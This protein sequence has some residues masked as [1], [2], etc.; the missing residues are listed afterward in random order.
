VR[1]PLPADI[2][3]LAAAQADLMSDLVAGM[4]D[5]DL[6]APTRCAGWLA[7]HLLVHVRLG[8]AETTG[9]F[10]QPAGAAEVT[11]RD[12]ISYWRD[13]PA[14]IEPVT[15][16]TVRWHWA[17]ASAYSV[18]AEFR[19]HFTDTAR[20]AAGVSRQAPAG[21]FSFQDHVMGAV[22]I[23][24]M[25][26]VVPGCTSRPDRVPARARWRATALTLTARTLDDAHADR[27][28]WDTRWPR[29]RVPG[30]NR[31]MRRRPIGERAAAFPAF[32]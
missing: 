24:E 16:A 13:W 5:A 19:R 1:E 3:E 27:P 23:F 29:S 22:D 18:A 17:N 30:R 31:S 7:A 32:G 9:S 10:A 25:S 28:S 4:S 21:R 14:A 20:A 11:D 6:V 15:F 26:T 12:F 2:R 8:L